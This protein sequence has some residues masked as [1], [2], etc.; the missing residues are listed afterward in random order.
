[1]TSN[2][3][4]EPLSIAPPESIAAA[5]LLEA[6]REAL[7]EILADERRE[8]QRERALIEA[9]A[10]AT[11]SGLK[12]EV[13]AL[14]GD[15]LERINARL[16][17]LKDGAPGEPGPAGP[18]GAPGAPGES[19][20]G[21]PGPPGEPGVGLV[22]ERGEP[23]LPG[24]DGESIVGERGP[25]GPPGEPGV[26]LPGPQG[27]PGIA[28]K[29]GAPGE[30]REV[31]AYA[32]GAVHYRGD[33]VTHNGA[34]FQARSDTAQAPPHEHWA[35]IAAAGKDAAQMQIRGTYDSAAQYHYLD[36]VAL[37]GSSFV[38]RADDPGEC[39][40]AGWQLIASAGRP[41]RPGLKGERGDPGA[42]GKGERGERGAP[43]E[44]APR[45]LAWTID[46]KAFCAV[47]VMSDGSQAPAIELRGLFEQFQL[48]AR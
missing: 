1:M 30:L 24:K 9:Q 48:E 13:A 5:T 39:P 37:N 27:E 29:D 46:R 47:P 44:A 6:W 4:P 41:G 19:I 14:R 26:G 11:I 33:L 35:C 34:T 15:M 40:G 38:A 32:A 7:A 25:P 45:I 16:A 42:A 2:G 3:K 28:G 21:P 36:I 10:A 18:P 43:G 17:E 31:K 22:G 23:G 8:W 20:A 12:A